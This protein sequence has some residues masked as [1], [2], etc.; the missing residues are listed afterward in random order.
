MSEQQIFEFDEHRNIRKYLNTDYFKLTDEMKKKAMIAWRA[1][2]KIII[3]DVKKSLNIS[4]NQY[5]EELERLGIPPRTKKTTKK[6]DKSYQV[7]KNPQSSCGTS[8]F[9]G[10]IN[11]NQLQ[12][13]LMRI[14]TSVDESAYLY[15]YTIELEKLS[16]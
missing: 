1:D 11:P 14:A 16:E 6:K 3:D 4:E 7:Q 15:R 10:T 8:L 13:E 2:R 9:K 12:D 5:Y